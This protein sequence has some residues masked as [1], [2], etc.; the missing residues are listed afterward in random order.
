MAV[1][2]VSRVTEFQVKGKKKLTLWVGALE[3]VLERLALAL[4]QRLDESKCVLAANGADNII[5]R[6][7]EQFGDDGEL[8]DVVL[9]GEKGLALEHLGEDATC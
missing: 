5:W 4:G 9:S 2:V 3:L 7:A 6:G 8:V 1:H